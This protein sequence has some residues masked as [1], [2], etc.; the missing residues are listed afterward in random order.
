L[1]FDAI[2]NDRAERF[3]A[4]WPGTYIGRC[5]YC[6]RGGVETFWHAE[7]KAFYCCDVWEC[8]EYSYYGYEDVTLGPP[9]K[10]EP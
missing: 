3:L 8:Q 9:D 2:Q 1:A 7:D 10:E 6:Y 5:A 4:A